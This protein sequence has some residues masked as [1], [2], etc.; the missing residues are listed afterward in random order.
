MAD[1]FDANET[2][3]KI[4][5]QAEQAAERIRDLNERIIEAAKKTGNTG[6]DAYEKA[7]TS[8]LEFET[9]AAEASQLDFINSLTQAHV[10]FVTDMSKVFTD[11]ARDALK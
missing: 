9:K 8:F 10:S 3:A 5:E 1:Q 2:V 6:L 4:T 7:L 11:A